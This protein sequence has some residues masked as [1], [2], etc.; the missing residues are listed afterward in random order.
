MILAY[1]IFA[2]QFT[3]K[4]ASQ[5]AEA[6]ATWARY[7]LEKGDYILGVQTLRN[8]LTSASFFASACFTTLS[9][10]VGIA[11]QRALSALDLIKYGTAAVLLVASAVSYL[12]SVRYMNSC[13]SSKGLELWAVMPPPPLSGGR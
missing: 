10:L 5:N 6:R 9:L 11:S 12:Q 8:A 2:K 4:W 7:I 13:V 1:Q 3:A